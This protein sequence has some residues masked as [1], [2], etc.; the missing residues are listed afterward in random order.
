MNRCCMIG[1][2]GMGHIHRGGTEGAMGWEK[3]WW[4]GIMGRLETRKRG[5]EL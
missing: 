1:M 5:Y 3:M 2:R 4:D